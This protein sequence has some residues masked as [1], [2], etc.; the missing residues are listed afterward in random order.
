MYSWNF[1]NSVRSDRK[2][3]TLPSGDHFGRRSLLGPA[4]MIS[5]VSSEVKRRQIRV[6]DGE[7]RHSDELIVPVN[8]IC[9]P[10]GD[11]A[12]SVAPLTW[13]ILGA[14]IPLR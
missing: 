2:A 14:I 6:F 8:A 13:L 10:L 7:L 1:P 9:R 4:V 12:K 3:N 5:K 11:A